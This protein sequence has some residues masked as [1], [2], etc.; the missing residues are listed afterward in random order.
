FCVVV[1]VFSFSSRRRHTILVSDWSSDVC[2][3][4]LP[5]PSASASAALR[6]SLTEPKYFKRQASGIPS[7]QTVVAGRLARAI[8]PL[9]LRTGRSEERRVGKSVDLG[10]GGNIKTKDKEVEE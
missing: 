2:S 1:V 9:P 10:G 5:S 4:D 7:F 3:S 6:T 8:T